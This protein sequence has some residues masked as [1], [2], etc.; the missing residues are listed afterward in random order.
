VT[1]FLSLAEQ[2]HSARII[3]GFVIS[4]EQRMKGISEICMTPHKAGGKSPGKVIRIMFFL[5]NK[6]IIEI[7]I[8][9]VLGVRN[10]M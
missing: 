4:V 3:N 9:K 10:L 8:T 7:L 1:Y 5:Y 2:I 6:N